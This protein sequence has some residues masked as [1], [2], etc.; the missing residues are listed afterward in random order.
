MSEDVLISVITVV[1]NGSKTLEQ[2]IK[3]VLGQTYKNIQYIII[4]GGSTDGTL[5]I[6]EKYRDRLHYFVS[7]KDNGIY[8]AMNKGL[9][10]ATG[11]LIGIINS[12][13]WY[14]RNAV[15]GVVD[16]YLKSGRNE[17]VFYGF[18]RILKDEQEFAI[19]RFHHN[20]AQHH[21]IQHPT[22]FVSKT[23][24]N[25]LG[26][27]DA[28]FKVA[29]DFDLLQR[30]HI[31]DVTFYPIDEVISNFREGGIS[32]YAY[33]IGRRE[34]LFLN[35]KYGK[36]SKRAFWRTSIKYRLLALINR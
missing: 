5:D 20:F 36:I 7:E 13:D 14:E 24:Y 29:G 12:D 30:F 34:Y 22:W 28:T 4:D 26:F 18:L 27:F 9:Q 10:V 8:D 23:L 19:R 1:F 21:M 17:G 15:R 25:K 11:E 16:K 31:N 33:R 2:T 35:Y 3:S 32:N 6:I